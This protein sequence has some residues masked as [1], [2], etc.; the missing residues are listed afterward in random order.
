MTKLSLDQ[1]KS[2]LGKK[3][4]IIDF[5]DLNEFT[6]P[7]DL[8]DRILSC[9]KDIFLDNERIVF[10]YSD[11]K[12]NYLLEVINQIDIPEFFAIILV[13]DEISFSYNVG[14]ITV[15]YLKGF[16]STNN[17]IFDIPTNHCIY[18]W[19]NLQ[20]DNL[21]FIT[22]CCVF[23]TSE[24]YSLNE[25]SL[26]DN[27]LSDAYNQI[28][29]SFRNNKQLSECNNC[30]LSETAN[31]QSMRVMAKHK[32]KDV[33]YKIDYTDNNLDDLQMLDLKLGYNCNLSCRICN[34]TNSSS[35]SKFKLDN[36]ELSLEKFNK[37]KDLSLWATSTVFYDNL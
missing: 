8:Y 21:G 19:I 1:Y 29:N 5:I 23:Q 17:K 36:N 25:R 2:Y 26:R 28:R 20:V 9:K 10:V 37:I 30:W 24:K 35:I 33:Y 4:N 14:D 15:L 11:N 18:P 16:K 6:H 3:Y 32:L 12:I 7:K 27:Y 34:E 13:P 31:I 22:P